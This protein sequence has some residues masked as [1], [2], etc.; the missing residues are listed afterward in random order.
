MTYH[1]SSRTPT[2]S[3]TADA[4]ETLA[5][6]GATPA[7]D[8]ID[9]RPLPEQDQTSCA[10]A[11]MVEATHMLL[12]DT[13]L[14]E[15]LEEMLWSLTNIFHRKLYLIERRLDDNE[16]EQRQMMREQDG[17][18]VKSLELERRLIQG[19][20]LVEHRKPHPESL[21]LACKQMGVEPASG[22]YVGDHIRDIEA[23]RNAGMTTVAVRYGYLEHPEDI[24]LWEADHTVETVSDL[25]KL[26]QCC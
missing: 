1:P 22:I 8:E 19:Q 23:G 7:P 15:D 21:L 17:S 20:Q 16:A 14:E 3:Q 2:S 12:S 18:E 10:I 6:Y 25:V 26:I 24:D 4:C 9:P 11:S 13:Q 5:L